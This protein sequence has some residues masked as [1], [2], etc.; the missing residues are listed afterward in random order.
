M[1]RVLTVLPINLAHKVVNILRKPLILGTTL[2]RRNKN[3]DQFRFLLPLRVVV[4][5]FIKCAQ[6]LWDAL[7]IV[8][9]IY[10]DNGLD[11]PQLLFQGGYGNSYLVLA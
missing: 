1:G 10:T 8:H 2:S 7:D 4:E 5:K 3:L 6:L 9:P 11:A